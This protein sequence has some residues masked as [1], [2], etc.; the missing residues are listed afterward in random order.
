[1]NFIN[2]GES[3]IGSDDYGCLFLKMIEHWRDVWNKRTN[4]ITNIQFPFG[5]VQVNFLEKNYF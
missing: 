2:K 1:L 4:G 5:F 3:N